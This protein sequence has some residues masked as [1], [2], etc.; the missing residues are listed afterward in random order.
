MKL[1]FE[2][3]SYDLPY[4]QQVSLSAYFFLCKE[5][6]SAQ[7]PYVGYFYSEHAKDSV[8]ILPKVFLFKGVGNADNKEIAFGK[9]RPEDIINVEDPSNPMRNDGLEKVAFS[10]SVWLYQSIQRYQARHKFSTIIENAKIGNVIS[11]K[12]N[13]DQTYLDVMLSMLR[14]HREHK[15]LF[16][17]ISI[18]NSS[19]NNKIH[20]GKTI[21]K[22]QPIIHEGI[23]YYAEFRNKDK[24]INFDEDIIVLFY[25]ALEYLKQKYLFSVDVNLNYDIIK[26]RRVEEM[27]ESGKGTRLLKSIRKKYFTDELVALWKLLFVFFQKAETIQ[28]GRYHE[29]ALLARNYNLV[30]EDMIDDLICDDLPEISHLKDT[31]DGKRI[32]HI[33]RDD[34]LIPKD[35]IFF[36]GDSK[37]YSDNNDIMGESIH[38]QFTYAKNIIQY[39][40]NILQKHEKGRTENEKKVISGIRYRDELTE[41]YNITPNFFIRGAIKEEY[42]F[43]GKIDFGDPGLEPD[44]QILP[45]NKQFPNRLFDRDTLILQTYRLNFL[46]VLATYVRGDRNK[47][48]K[49]ETH[50]RFRED[51]IKTFDRRYF[52]YKVTPFDETTN[53]IE[54]FVRKHFKLLIGKIYRGD[55]DSRFLWLALEK[56]VNPNEVLKIIRKEAAVKQVTLKECQIV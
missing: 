6:N 53:G 14:F 4:V 45:F 42:I 24:T 22:V 55:D 25:S 29:E 38:K 49:E 37:Y 1:L 10:L 47:G 3:Y 7:V 33:Y 44:G 5:L 17:Y 34:S 20:W 31:K 9:Y 52:F 11:N 30:F 19:G 2:E 8:F 27:I 36:I 56:R 48:F 23:P 21:S 28:K 50:R 39:S 13:S 40:L 51:I 12:G 18:I 32:D 41:G 15:N 26:P 46:Y 54:D 35:K 16:T 43:K